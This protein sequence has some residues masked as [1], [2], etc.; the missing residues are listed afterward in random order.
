[1]SDSLVE[2]L[3]APNLIHQKY[4]KQILETSCYFYMT[5]AIV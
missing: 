5:G 4:Q 1:M 3:P 2:K